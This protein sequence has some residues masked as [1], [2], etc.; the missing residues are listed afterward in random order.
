VDAR[1]GFDFG[2]GG[3]DWAVFRIGERAFVVLLFP[4][5]PYFPFTGETSGPAMGLRPLDLAAWIEPDAT[6]AARLM[7]KAE[8]LRE[9]RA[10]VLG[11]EPDTLDA[12]RELYALLADHLPRH[13]PLDYHR[14][15]GQL[16]VLATGRTYPN[17]PPADSDPETLLACISLWIQEDLCLLSPVA[18]VRLTAG[19]VCFPSRWNLPEKLGLDS[20]AIHQPVPGFKAALAG[21]TRNF[22]ERITVEK[23]VWRL[24]WTIHDS[25]QLFAPHPIPGR[26]D[27]T[28][29]SVLDATFLRVE[30]QTLR[31]LPA[32]GA[33]VFTIRTYLHSMKDV[34]AD[35]MRREVLRQTLRTLPEEVVAYKG[36]ATLIRP[37]RTALGA[38]GE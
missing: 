34:A 11:A 27:L 12:C 1:L 22:L 25:D 5:L 4:V 28:E 19:S 10:L 13:H 30:R 16:R 8:L 20:G 9:Q 7:L 31:R 35:A 14:E 23:P 33:V 15:Q 6:D 32:T 38:R 24:N 3:E 2:G 21:P 18:P 37:L 29:A 36:M 26:Q 17:S